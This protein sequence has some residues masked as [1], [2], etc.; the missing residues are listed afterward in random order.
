MNEN[1]GKILG[2]AGRGA[3][4]AASAVSRRTGELVESARLRLRASSLEASVEETL[5]QV[6]AML[7]ATHTGT[8]ANSE[9]LQR[10]LEEI[11]RLNAELA[12]VNR[13]LGRTDTAVC[14]VCGAKSR[15]GDMFCRN[16]GGRL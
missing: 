10:K 16:C 1:I 7:Y 12:E 4:S 2:A 5:E 14:P 6:G 3:A 11:D 13:R 9:T 8:P 15:S